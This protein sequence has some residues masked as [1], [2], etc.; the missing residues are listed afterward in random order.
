MQEYTRQPKE[1]W[2]VVWEVPKDAPIGELYY[3]VTATDKFGRTTSFEPFPNH[4]TYLAIV[5]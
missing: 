4:L 3:T 2:T 1:M 5:E